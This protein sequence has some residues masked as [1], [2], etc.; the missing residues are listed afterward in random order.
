MLGMLILFCLALNM[1]RAEA[2]CP[3]WAEYYTE[4]Y[5]YS[6]YQPYATEAADLVCSGQ[7]CMEDMRDGW[8]MHGGFY[9]YAREFAL[10]SRAHRGGCPGT[11]ARQRSTSPPQGTPAGEPTVAPLLPNSQYF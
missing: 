1:Q 7:I 5:E 4:F 11:R 8:K 2:S 6:G 3:R 10:N 9:S